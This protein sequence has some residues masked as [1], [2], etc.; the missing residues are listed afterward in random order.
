MWS[1]QLGFWLII[2]PSFYWKKSWKIL[3]FVLQLGCSSE[4]AE[5]NVRINRRGYNGATHACACGGS[6]EYDGNWLSLQ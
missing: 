4:S 1:I 6:G 3:H 5:Y 2:F